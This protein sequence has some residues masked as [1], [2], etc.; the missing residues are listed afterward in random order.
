M[1]EIVVARWKEA[2]RRD[3]MMSRSGLCRAIIAGKLTMPPSRPEIVSN[4][5]GVWLLIVV[6]FKETGRKTDAD[7]LVG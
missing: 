1:T 6:Y 2:R 7:S 5:V 3:W 4:I